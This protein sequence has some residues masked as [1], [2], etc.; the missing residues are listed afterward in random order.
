MVLAASPLACIRLARAV[1]HPDQTFAGVF[2]D[3]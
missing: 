2:I 3:D 1:D